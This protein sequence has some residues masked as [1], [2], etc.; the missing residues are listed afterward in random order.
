MS[1][2]NFI[3]RNIIKFMMA[4]LTVAVLL[5]GINLPIVSQADTPVNEANA[6]NP[7]DCP[8]DFRINCQGI[9]YYAVYARPRESQLNNP[10]YVC[11]INVWRL[12]ENDEGFF[13]FRITRAE[14]E[15]LTTPPTEN[16][17]IKSR[18]D[19]SFYHLTSGEFQINAGPDPEGKVFTI[20]FE[21]C[22]ATNV[23]EQA[24]E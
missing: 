21:G 23:R 5:G 19:I 2:K 13:A 16:R 6:C 12:G 20:I 22:P 8:H 17:L 18:L 9:Q 4:T 11:E 10:N 7:C 15:T 24:L 1:G 3:K 14:L